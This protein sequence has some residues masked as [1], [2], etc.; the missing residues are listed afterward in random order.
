[1]AKYFP[2]SIL[3][4]LVF[5]VAVEAHSFQIDVE[6][7]ARYRTAELKEHEVEMHRLGYGFRHVFSDRDGDRFLLFCRIEGEHNFSLFLMEQAYAQYKGPMGRWNITAGRFVIP[8][9]LNVTYET[10]SLLVKTTAEKTITNKY[11]SGILF[12]GR[13]DNFEYAL[14]LTQ[15][16]GAR[17]WIDNDPGKLVSFRIGVSGGEEEDYNFGISG[18][19][20]SVYSNERKQFKKLFAIDG[21]KYLGQLIFRGEFTLGLENAERVY[22]LFLGMDYRFYQSLDLSI[23]F[24]LFHRGTSNMSATVGLAYHTP[25]FGFVIRAAHTL[26]IGGWYNESFIQVYN[27]H[28]F[29]F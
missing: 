1:M 18:M 27:K 19:T 22:G 13:I 6:G 12:S 25:F 29:V 7:D 14:S 8:F 16:I 28:S 3:S 24:N 4:A 23:A 17:R 15:G 10:E 21:T 26:T 20:G 5:L 9:G 11:D 2:V